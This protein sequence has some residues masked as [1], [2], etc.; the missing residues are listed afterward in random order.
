MTVSDTGMSPSGTATVEG[1]TGSHTCRGKAMSSCPRTPN[2]NVE[3]MRHFVWK[4]IGSLLRN[5]EIGGSG[6]Q[7]LL[8]RSCRGVNLLFLPQYVSQAEMSFSDTGTPSDSYRRRNKR[9]H[10]CW[11][12]AMSSCPRTPNFNVEHMRHFV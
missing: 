9:F 3:H 12:K 5:I 8:A 1:T 6:V 4:N 7:M 11:G 10:P 2:F